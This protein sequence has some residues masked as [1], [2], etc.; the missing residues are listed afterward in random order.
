MELEYRPNCRLLQEAS[1]KLLAGMYFGL[2]PY[3]NPADK[4]LKVGNGT[5][6]TAMV[7]VAQHGILPEINPQLLS[8]DHGKAFSAD[9][10]R[11][12]TEVIGFAKLDETRTVMRLVM[13]KENATYLPSIIPSHPSPNDLARIGLALIQELD[14][15]NGQPT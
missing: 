3:G 9:L 10:L 5:F 12:L 2:A 11:F 8:Q 6:H 13:E 1:W 4:R 14:R 15:L 7:R